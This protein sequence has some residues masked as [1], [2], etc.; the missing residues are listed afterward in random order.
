MSVQAP[1]PGSAKAVAIKQV[2]TLLKMLAA[3]NDSFIV[4][5]AGVTATRVEDGGDP[6]SVVRTAT[7][8]SVVVSD[9]VFVEEHVQ[10]V[11]RKGSL[12]A[13]DDAVQRIM[14]WRRTLGIASISNYLM[15]L[16]DRPAVRWLLAATGLEALAV[17]RLGPQPQLVGLLDSSAK[18]GLR[19]GIQTALQDAGVNDAEPQ[20]RAVEQL[21]RTT[22]EPVAAHVRRYLDVVEVPNVSVDEIT[23]WWR[24]RGQI[25]HGSTVNT[26]VGELSRL[27]TCFQTALRRELGI[28]PVPA[29]GTS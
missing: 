25:A 20:K 4:R 19:S 15:V 14:I 17:G 27:I 29:G 3:S 22:L 7:G 10:L 13:E 28:E 24:T 5:V 2:E 9:T 18:S 6:T 23:L 11:K 12:A 26:D 8:Y 1:N 21:L 16:S